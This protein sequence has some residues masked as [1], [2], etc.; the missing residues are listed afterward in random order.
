MLD[1]LQ[2]LSLSTA[3]RRKKEFRISVH[4]QRSWHFFHP[5]ARDRTRDGPNGALIDCHCQELPEEK[6][7]L[8]IVTQANELLK[9]TYIFV[10]IIRDR[11][12]NDTRGNFTL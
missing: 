2:T 12:V 1:C 9:Y 6:R 8:K 10:P 4:K 7:I 11:K 3:F 5:H